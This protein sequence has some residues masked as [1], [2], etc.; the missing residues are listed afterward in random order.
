AAV[1]GTP[2]ATITFGGRLRG[3]LDLGRTMRR[4]QSSRPTRWYL[5]HAA[6]RY[7]MPPR[8]R[9]TTARKRTA[10]PSG[11]SAGETAPARGPGGPRP[12]AP[13]HEAPAG[14]RGP[15]GPL[16]LPALPGQSG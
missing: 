9:A 11:G 13:G 12:R 3:D 15:C 7:G 10:G 4:L 2:F 16:P 8:T 1:T 6:A 14:S 5:A